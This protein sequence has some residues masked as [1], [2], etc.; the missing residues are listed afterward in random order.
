[1]RVLLGH[2]DQ[3]DNKFSVSS[4]N[5]QC[6]AMAITA[7]CMGI[8]K[9]PSTWNAIDIDRCLYLGDEMYRESVASLQTN[10]TFVAGKHK[11][12][13]NSG[14]SVCASFRSYK[15]FDPS[16][17]GRSGGHMVICPLSDGFSLP[18]R[19]SG[20]RQRLSPKKKGRRF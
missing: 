14:G 1:M 18:R 12:A 4:R 13:A 10:N 16:Q 15:I 11:M 7:I 9:D 8:T 3:S 5:H 6:T 17:S 2:F 19:T 20:V